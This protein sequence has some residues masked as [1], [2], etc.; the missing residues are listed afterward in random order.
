MSKTFHVDFLDFSH[1]VCLF[2]PCLSSGKKTERTRD[3]GRPTLR[4]GSC[5]CK[6]VTN[7][8]GLRACVSACVTVGPMAQ[9]LCMR[10]DEEHNSWSR[11]S[12]VGL[13]LCR[14]PC[15]PESAKFSLCA[16][17]TG[18]KKNCHGS[19]RCRRGPV[20]VKGKL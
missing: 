17:S 7:S 13:K 2:D 5:V 3:Q 10:S 18:Q 20:R 14:R 9:E 16:E 12:C 11:Y 4:S 15:C 1:H 19:C 6:A 8:S